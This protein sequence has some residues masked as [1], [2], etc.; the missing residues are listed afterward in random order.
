MKEI[1][2]DDDRWVWENGRKF[3]DIVNRYGVTEQQ[4][5]ATCLE[6]GKLVEKEG[7]DTTIFLSTKETLDEPIMVNH[8][9]DQRKMES[10]DE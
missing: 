9:T 6:V 3:S 10:A 2:G 8:R 7:R 5:L 1:I 4:L